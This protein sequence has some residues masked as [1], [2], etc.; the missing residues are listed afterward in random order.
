MTL[1]SKY[2]EEILKQMEKPELLSTP[3]AT[4]ILEILKV[5]AEIIKTLSEPIFYLKESNGE[6]S[7]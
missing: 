6:H 3:N 5:H 1:D 4:L 2:P 7:K